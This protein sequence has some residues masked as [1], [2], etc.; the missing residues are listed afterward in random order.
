M[1]NFLMSRKCLS[2]QKIIIANVFVFIIFSQAF[3]QT[4]IFHEKIRRV[5]VFPLKV[6][7]EI[8][9]VAESIWWDLREN[10][11]ES[12][13]FLI[14]SKNFMSAKDVFQPRGEL[15]PA[16]AIILGRLLDANALI[17]TFVVDRKVSM[18]VYETQNGLT[19]WGGDIDMHPAVQVSKQ[20][21]DVTKKLLLDFLSSIPYQGFVIVDN[22]IGR[23]IYNE[24][25]KLMF[26]ADVGVGTQV[27][28]GDSVQ[29]VKIS[30]ERMKPLF[31]DG[32]SITVYAEGK[33]V[34]VDRHIITVQVIRRQENED[35]KADAL[36]RIPDELRRIKDIYGLHDSS[37][38]NLEVSSMVNREEKLTQ[39]QKDRK[40]LVAA[41]SWIGNL[42]LMLIIAL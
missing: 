29:L 40:P 6:D 33:V 17:T 13:R 22:L 3:A 9:K 34:N 19:L 25:E 35:I 20:L 36:I 42:A 2:A 24:G 4:H 30:A 28:L 16:D 32:A 7:K 5:T 18:R 8:D 23:P 14:A 21:P 27:T 39:Q 10:L 41:L 12:K 11:A 15:Q 38:K 31:I 1:V 37:E 26:K